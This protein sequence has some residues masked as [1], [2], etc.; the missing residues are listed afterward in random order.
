[1]G[2]LVLFG[3]GYSVV[4]SPDGFDWVRMIGLYAGIPFYIL[5]YVIYKYAYKTKIIPLMECD[6]VSGLMPVR[7]EDLIQVKTTLASRLGV[8]KSRARHFYGK[9]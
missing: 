4:A 5:L 9:K 7:D 1:M 2:L 6:L 8:F 3:E